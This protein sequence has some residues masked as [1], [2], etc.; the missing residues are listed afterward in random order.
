MLREYKDTSMQACHRCSVNKTMQQQQRSEEAGGLRDL[1]KSHGWTQTSTIFSTPLLLSNCLILRLVLSTECLEK[2]ASTQNTNQC[3]SK[4]KPSMFI[5]EVPL[6]CMVTV[7]CK[8]IV[9]DQKC[10]ITQLTLE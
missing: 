5:V 8:L 6:G 3:S 9:L 7:V 10:Q 2:A 1:I 4:I